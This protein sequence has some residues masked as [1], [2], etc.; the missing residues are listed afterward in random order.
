MRLLPI[1]LVFIIMTK[2]S[3]EGMV[4]DALKVQQDVSKYYG[5]TLK[6]SSDLKTNACCTG[7][8]MPKHIKAALSKVHPEVTSRYYGCGLCVPDELD[9]LSVLDLGCGA[10]RDVFLI[11]QLV[12]EQGCVVGV[13]MTK[14]QIE[15]ARE[16]AAWHAEKFG[17]AAPN[18]KF[19]DGKIE[20]LGACGLADGAFDLIVSNCVINLSTDKRAV[21]REAHRVL[22]DGG[23]LYFS[24][25]YASRRVP[26]ELVADPVLYGECLSGALYW[27][28]FLA[29]AKECGF[30]D[31]RLVDDSPITINNQELEAKV[32]QIDFFSATYRLFKLPQGTHLEPDC[33]DY[34]QSV[35]YKGTID[36]H[37][38]GWALDNHHFMETGKTFAVCGNTYH[39][40]HDTRFE[41]HFDFV[42]DKRRHYGIFEGCGKS[43]PFSSKEGGSGGGGGA[44]C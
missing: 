15:V 39:M 13:D 10:G 20:D 18:T 14:A 2:R 32:G 28:D 33:E 24:D 1:S 43:L 19:V 11:S 36:R 17:Y 40:L 35:I 16:H 38:H 34:G 29:L 5:D 44:C 31:P 42:G 4:L 26:D 9:G 37:P 25:V 22:R 3:A 7:A 8:D 27:N 23:E 21:L 12:G 41:P 30:H 6:S